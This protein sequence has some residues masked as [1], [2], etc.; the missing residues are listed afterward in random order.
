MLN[1]YIIPLET[2]Q[3]K[4]CNKNKLQ[5]VKIYVN[6]TLE[7]GLAVGLSLVR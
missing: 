5:T 1:V 6:F 7:V 3:Q 2:S 4:Q